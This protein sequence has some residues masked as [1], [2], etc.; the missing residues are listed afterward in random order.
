MAFDLDIIE[1]KIK[2][3]IANAPQKV[4]TPPHNWD[5]N[6]TR[7]VLQVLQSLF[8]EKRL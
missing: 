5:G 6:A 7:R 8:F 1:K 3:I 2:N 4:G